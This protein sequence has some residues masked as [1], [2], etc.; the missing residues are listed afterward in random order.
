MK[1][2]LATSPHVRHPMVLQNDFQVASSV[3]LTFIPIGLLSLVAS[4][5][6]ALEVEP[7][8]FDLNRRIIDGTVSIGSAFYRSAAAELCSSSPDMIGFMTENESYHHVLQICREIKTVN[9]D[10]IVVLGGPH[11]SA[12]AAATFRSW[13][14]IDYI[15]SGEGEVSFPDLIRSVK[16]DGGKLVPGVW[17]RSPQGEIAF[18]GDRPLIAELDMLPYPA[19][20]RYQPDRD[21]E[22]FFEVGRGCPFQCSFC[23]TAPFWRRTHRV[24][25][26]TRILKELQHV[27]RLYGGRRMHFTHDLF[28][29]NKTWVQEVCHA[30]IAAGVPVKWTCS[31][32]TDTVDAKALELMASAGCDAIYFGLE[33]GSPRILREIK[34]NIPLEHSFETLRHCRDVGITANVGFIGGLPNEDEQS[35]SETFSAYGRALEMGCTPVH[36]FQFVPYQESSSIGNLGD[37]ICN[38]HFLDL[39]LGPEMDTANRALLADDPIVFGPYHRPRQRADDIQEELIDGL[40]EFPTLVSTA[41]LVTL[42]L[43]RLSGGMFPLFKRWIAWISRFN[44]QRKATPFRRCFGTPLLFSDFLLEE[45]KL[46]DNFPSGLL[47][48]LQVIHMSQQIASGEQATMP[49]TMANYRTGLPSDTWPTIQLSTDLALGDVVGQLQLPMD[50]EALLLTKPPDLPPD[51]EPGPMYLL[52]QRVAPGKVQLLKVDAFTFHV[53][54]ELRTSARDAGRILQAWTT[55]HHGSGREQDLFALVHQLEEATRMGIIQ[56]NSVSAGE[57]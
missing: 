54:T 14:C 57:D 40:E 24:K 18:G 53:V 50:I 4:V 45:A 52:W 56:R 49:T 55:D 35:L 42:A 3:M 2:V 10:C 17:G 41:P 47:L 20:E 26:A 31:S 1:I 9:R 39:P 37:R 23:S 32:R 34:K 30:L 7:S 25:S 46:H 27:T 12:V 33:S 15:V 11:A 48:L 29:T 6:S 28:T 21:E 36:L 13:P 5:R 43:A 44:D 38:G 8:V 16:E 19:Y 22:I 51:P